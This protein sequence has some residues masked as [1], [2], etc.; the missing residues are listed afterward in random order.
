MSIEGSIKF[1]APMETDL[2]KDFYFYLESTVH[3]RV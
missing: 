1:P 2:K 3:L